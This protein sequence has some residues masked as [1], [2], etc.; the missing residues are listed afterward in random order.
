MN[1]YRIK[2]IKIYLNL[3]LIPENLELYIMFKIKLKIIPTNL[4]TIIVQIINF[5]KRTKYKNIC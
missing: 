2:I 1:A 5:I 4:I 3:E